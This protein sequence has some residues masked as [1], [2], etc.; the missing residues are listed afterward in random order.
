LAHDLPAVWQAPQTSLADKRQVARLLLQQVVVWAPAASREMQVRL[1]WTGG[2][3]TEHRLS[4]PVRAWSQ[5]A[6]RDAL[7]ERVRQGRA[8][9]QTSRQIAEEFNAAGYRTPRGRPFTA[10][11]LRQLRK[12]LG[13]S[14]PKARRRRPKK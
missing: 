2:T 8:T 1:H 11:S 10:A 13:R 5:V 4:R 9:G 7:V 3:V 14:L 12:R 6:E